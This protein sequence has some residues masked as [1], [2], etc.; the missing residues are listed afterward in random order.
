MLPVDKKKPLIGGVLLNNY[1]V[2]LAAFLAGALLAVF[3]GAFAAVLVAAFVA[4][5]LAAGL[6]SDL[7]G[8][9]LAKNW[10][11]AATILGL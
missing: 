8:L 5:F 10:S 4:V 6:A 9:V 1:F 7:A 11:K 3:L 2:A